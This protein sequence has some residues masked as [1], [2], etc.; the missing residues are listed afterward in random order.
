MKCYILCSKGNF[1]DPHTLLQEMEIYSARK[2]IELYL[3]S[4]QVLSECIHL[5][6]VLQLHYN[7]NRMS[8]ANFIIATKL[9]GPSVSFI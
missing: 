7:L 4:K 1:Y 9:S 8:T 5:F 2:I 3:L 6:Y